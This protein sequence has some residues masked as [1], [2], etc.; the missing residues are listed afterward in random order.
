MSL[1]P[2]ISGFS[3][4][5]MQALF[6]SE[7]EDSVSAV[8]EELREIVEFDDPQELDRAVQVVERALHRGVPFPD[9]EVEGEPHA[10]AA[11]ALAMHG[12]NPLVTGS[13]VWMMDAFE[14]FAKVTEGSLSDEAAASFRYLLDGRPLFGQRIETEWNLYAWLT[15]EEVNALR[16]GLEGVREETPDPT[17][18]GFLGD[19]LE[20]VGEISDSGMDLWFHAG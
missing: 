19:L 4:A 15:L 9:L 13:N 3:L 5:A 18:D 12:Q 20:W 10:V 14:E 11:I 2:E 17:D 1:R 8:R 7:D 16:R 6:G